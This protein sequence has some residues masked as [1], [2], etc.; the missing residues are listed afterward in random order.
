MVVFLFLA[1]LTTLWPDKRAAPLDDLF[2]QRMR[3]ALSIVVF[4]YVFVG[5]TAHYWNYMWIFWGVCLGIANSL[6]EYSLYVSTERS[7]AADG[8]DEAASW[9]FDPR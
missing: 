3:T 6:R 8:S 2:L 9:A 1:N 4:M 5:F 7:Q